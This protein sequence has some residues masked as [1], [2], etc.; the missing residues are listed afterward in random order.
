MGF[1]KAWKD[2]PHMAT[3]EHLTPLSGGGDNSRKNLVLACKRC[4][5]AKQSMPEE[6]FWEMVN[7]RSVW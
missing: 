4:N 6:E 1:G 2:H 5:E 7:S 3:I